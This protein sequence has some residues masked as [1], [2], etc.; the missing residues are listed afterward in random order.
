ME[1]VDWLGRSGVLETVGQYESV[2][3]VVRFRNKRV[4]AI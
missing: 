2:V 1:R 4:A 3:V